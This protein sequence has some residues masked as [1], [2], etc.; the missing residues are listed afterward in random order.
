MELLYKG[1]YTPA[2]NT[3]G[4]L[5][6]LF[7]FKSKHMASRCIMVRRMKPESMSE[8]IKAWK[9]VKTENTFHLRVESQA[10]NWH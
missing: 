5:L 3:L 9:E 1:F 4:G 7:S 6:R 10:S 2:T 8:N